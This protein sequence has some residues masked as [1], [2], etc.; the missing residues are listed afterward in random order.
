MTNNKTP[1]PDGIPVEVYKQ[2][3]KL[4]RL[5]HK[6]WLKEHDI[7]G[8][9]E[10]S[11]MVLIYKEKREREDMANYRPLQMLNTDYKIVAKA[12]ANRLQGVMQ[13]V[14]HP[15]QTGF[16]KG[17]NIKDNIME[18]YLTTVASKEGALI[19]LDFKKAYNRMDRGWIKSVMTNMNLGA[20]FTDWLMKLIEQSQI[21]VTMDVIS[22]C[23]MALSGV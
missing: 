1:G 4:V 19:L 10:Q 16:I 12:M 6:T 9:M 18:T 2:Y 11:N 8:N 20:R 7:T 23:F 21:R 14:I 13:H 5:L 15:D 3:P 22:K 17:R